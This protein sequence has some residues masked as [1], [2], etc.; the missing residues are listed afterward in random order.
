MTR[1]SA[2]RQAGFCT[3]LVLPVWK[4]SAL[5]NKSLFR[6]LLR[7]VNE[8][9]SFSHKCPG[10]DIFNSEFYYSQTYKTRVTYVTRRFLIDHDICTFWENMKTSVR[11]SKNVVWIQNFVS[12]LVECVLEAQ[13]IQ[14]FSP[15][16]SIRKSSTIVVE[17]PMLT[18]KC[19][20]H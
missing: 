18:L 12:T 15:H 17:F 11:L 7:E 14:G 1:G 19:E 10:E 20:I 5:H 3:F 13:V 9:M 2:L 8:S 6:L 16:I 4:V